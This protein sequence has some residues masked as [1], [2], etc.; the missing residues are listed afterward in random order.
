[1]KTRPPAVAGL[2]YP[3]DPEALRR[4][5]GGFLADAGESTAPPTPARYAA[6]IV[7]HAGYVYS[8]STAA[9]VYKRLQS[10]ADKVQHVVIVGPA[11]RV[12]IRALALPDADALATPLGDV[13]V[14]PEGARTAL[15]QPG[16]EISATVHAQEHSVEVQLPFVQT[17]LPDADVLPL[18][19]GWITPEVVADTLAALPTD[20]TFFLISSDLSH[21][22]PYSRAQSIDQATVAQILALDP[23]I[24]HDQ[25]CGATGVD[26]IL[27]HARARGLTPRLERLCNSGDTAGDKSAVVGYA[28]VSFYEEVRP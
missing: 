11:H 9:L 22:H 14:W 12:G 4:M 26:A 15:A 18:V 7:P 10:I 20:G 8:G 2:F 27:R 21:Y 5:I 6:A 24:D 3:A 13:R 16:V 28:A 25:A 1:M 23:T 19:A 17:V